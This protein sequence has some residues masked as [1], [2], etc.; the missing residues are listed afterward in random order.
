MKFNFILVGL[1]IGFSAVTHAQMQSAANKNQA[2]TVAA[3]TA[4]KTSSLTAQGAYTI[5]SD[6]DKSPK[7]QVYWSALRI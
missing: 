7:K 3:N 2:T 5:G 6:R 4:V 1:T